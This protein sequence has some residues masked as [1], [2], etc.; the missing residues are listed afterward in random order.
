MGRLAGAIDLI[1]TLFELMM[2]GALLILAPMAVF[3]RTRHLAGI[4]FMIATPVFAFLLWA[5]AAMSVYVYWGLAPV[6]L[7]TLGFGLGT[8]VTAAILII[9]SGT[10]TELLGLSGMIVVTIISGIVAV[11][12]DRV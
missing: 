11:A 8:V 2:A 12:L 9:M 10:G 7:S 1:P 3:R 6:I 4:G 5:A